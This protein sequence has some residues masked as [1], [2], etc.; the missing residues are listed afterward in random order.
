MERS[1]RILLAGG[2][3]AATVIPYVGY[4]FAG[5]MP[6]VEDARGMGFIGLLLGAAAWLILGIGAFG[7]RLIA[8]GGAVVAAALGIVAA[9]LETGTASSIFLG[10]FVAVIV[11]MYLVALYEYLHDAGHW[12]THRGMTA[13]HI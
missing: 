5:E 7:T 11:L 12:K 4:A 9:V 8:I 2:L 1:T 6:F 13:G 3:V 10:A